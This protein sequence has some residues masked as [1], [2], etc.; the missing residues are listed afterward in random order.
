M[1]SDNHTTS[2][3]EKILTI[4]VKPGWKEGTKITFQNEGDQGPNIIPGMHLEC[5]VFYHK[6]AERNMRVCRNI[7]MN[8]L[9]LFNLHTASKCIL[10]IADIIFEVKDKEHLY[11]RRDGI[12]LIHPV[13]IPLMTVNGDTNLITPCAI[14]SVCVSGSV[15]RISEDQNS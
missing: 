14:V 5:T 15:W 4:N 7:I 1:N 3:K 9:D 12:D 8:H 2:M 10:S 13:E 6:M 11:F